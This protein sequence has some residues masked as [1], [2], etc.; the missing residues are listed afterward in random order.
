MDHIFIGLVLFGLF[1]LLIGLFLQ[2]KRAVNQD[3]SIFF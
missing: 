1:S 3:I 2:L